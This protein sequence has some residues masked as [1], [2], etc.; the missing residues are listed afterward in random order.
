[1]K[2]SVIAISVFVI[3]MIV[4]ATSPIF[5]EMNDNAFRE[6]ANFVS[7]QSAKTLTFSQQ[8]QL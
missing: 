3:T 6:R 5:F 1:M 8:P 7:D 4:Y 2:N